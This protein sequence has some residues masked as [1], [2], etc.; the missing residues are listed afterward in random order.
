MVM[1]RLVFS[2]LAHAVVA[3]VVR[4]RTWSERWRAAAG[5]WTVWGTL[6][7][8]GSLASLAWLARA[9]GGSLVA[10]TGIKRETLGRDV[11]RGLGSLLAL[12]PSVAVSNLLAR[13]FTRGTMPEQ[14]GVLRQLPSWATAYS[15]IVWPPLWALAEETTY[16]GYVLPRLMRRTGH[17]WLSVVLVAAAWALQHLALPFLPDRRYLGVRAL[18]ALPVTAATTAQFVMKGRDLP[19]TIVAHWLADLPTALLARTGHTDDRS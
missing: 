18:T 12:V 10:L 19:P 11:V 6:V 13:A 14:V 7:D 5:W 9:E 4:Q 17:T 2:L 3:T 16:L 1:S 8:L 15:L